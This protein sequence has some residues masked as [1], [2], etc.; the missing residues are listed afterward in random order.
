MLVDAAQTGRA[1]LSATVVEVKGFNQSGA[2][3]GVNAIATRILPNTGAG[4]V[5]LRRVDGRYEF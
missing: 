4:R 1:V 5:G 2:G 3:G